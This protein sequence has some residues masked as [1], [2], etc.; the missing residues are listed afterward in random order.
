MPA[1][2]TLQKY[3]CDPCK[4]SKVRL[5]PRFEGC[6]R[7]TSNQVRCSRETVGCSRCQSQVLQCAYS[8]SGVIRRQRKTSNLPIANV[9]A[10]QSPGV[11][12]DEHI[13]HSESH[14]ASDIQSTKG[15]LAGS[16]YVEVISSLNSLLSLSAQSASPG[17]R[18]HAGS[19]YVHPAL[20]REWATGKYTSALPQ[21]LATTQIN[22]IALS[23]RERRL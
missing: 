5:R 18:Q 12:T 10:P 7:L 4:A 3:A 16:R 21:E 23:F 2:H 15:C 6:W 19:Y 11:E 9:S 22:K 20:V 17:S 14:L 13:D 8:R 1:H